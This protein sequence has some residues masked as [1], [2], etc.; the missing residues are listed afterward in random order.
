MFI[1]ERWQNITFHTYLRVHVVF[2]CVYGCCVCLNYILAKGSKD[3]F[4][5]HRNPRINV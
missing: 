5:V 4:N 3:I 2:V 1:Y